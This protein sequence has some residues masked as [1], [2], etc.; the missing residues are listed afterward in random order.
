MLV[1]IFVAIELYD[2]IFPFSKINSL[3]RFWFFVFEIAFIFAQAT[4]DDKASPLKPRVNKSYKSEKSLI[5]EVACLL[6]ALLKS[7][8][9]IPMPSSVTL[10]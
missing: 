2:F 10:I 5:F 3:P 7:S 9:S 4:I 6:K 1:P 8:S